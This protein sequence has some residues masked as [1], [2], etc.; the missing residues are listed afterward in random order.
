[1]KKYKGVYKEA[2]KEIKKAQRKVEIST[3]YEKAMERFNVIEEGEDYFEFSEGILTGMFTSTTKV[4]DLIGR[5]KIEGKDFILEDKYEIKFFDNFILGPIRK[6]RLR[7]IELEGKILLSG[8]FVYKGESIR[9][10]IYNEILNPLKHKWEE[11]R[12]RDCEDIFARIIF[13]KNEAFIAT[14]TVG[15]NT[16]FNTAY[17]YCPIV[18]S[19]TF[20]EVPFEGKPEN[21]QELLGDLKKITYY[22]LEN[23][24]SKNTELAV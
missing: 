3:S 1:M 13:D 6:E 21:L 17:S 10:E 2:L 14:R 4:A 8:N 23:H 20:D 9:V 22:Y 12:F 16:W 15:E 18:F 11:S 5:V 19:H 7:E 24:K